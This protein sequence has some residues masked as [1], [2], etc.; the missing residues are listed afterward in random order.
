MGKIVGA[1]VVCHQPGIMAPEEFRRLI[2]EAGRV[3][4]SRKARMRDQLIEE[5]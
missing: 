2:D 3:I 5:S 1:A 4:G